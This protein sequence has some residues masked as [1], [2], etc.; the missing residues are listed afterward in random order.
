MTITKKNRNKKKGICRVIVL[1]TNKVKHHECKWVSFFIRKSPF[2]Q[3]GPFIGLTLNNEEVGKFTV[4]TRRHNYA[5]YWHGYIWHSHI[6]DESKI[7]L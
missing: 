7:I 6:P 1:P 2:L 4:G 3:Q 5:N